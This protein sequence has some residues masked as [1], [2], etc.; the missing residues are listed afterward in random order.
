MSETSPGNIQVDR[1]EGIVTVTL[2]N[3]SKLNAMTRAMWIQFAEVWEELNEDQ[4]TRCIV[5]TGAGDRG[6]CP[7]N[8]IGEFEAFRSNAEKARALSEIMNRGR[9][10]MLSCPFP[11]VGK[12]RGACVGGGL[13]IAAMCD[14]RICS[15]NS[16][17][18]AP[19]N[20][21][22]LTMAYEEMLPIWRIADRPTM[23]EFLVEGRIIDALDAKTR[24]LVNRVVSAENL[25]EEVSATAQAIGDGPPLV[26]R[27]HKRFFNRLERDIPLTDADHDEHYLAFETQDYQTGYKSFLAKTKPVFRGR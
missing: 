13:E 12:I 3:P 14:M 6:F 8:D 16:R 1:S 21:L 26:H 5:V 11:V 10:A 19:L 23:F 4:E 24:G 15:D 22:G 20:R 2:N 18:G 25:D 7:G 27:W 9:E 17:F